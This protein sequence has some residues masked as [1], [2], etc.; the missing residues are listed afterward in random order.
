MA[1]LEITDPT[2]L[3]TLRPY[4]KAFQKTRGEFF[5]IKIPEFALHVNLPTTCANDPLAIFLLYYIPEIIDI[6]VRNTND[7]I[8]KP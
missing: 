7:F 5:P 6:I 8:L 1:S 4:E 2:D 3:G